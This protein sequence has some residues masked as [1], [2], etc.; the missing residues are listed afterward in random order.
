MYNTVGHNILF[1]IMFEQ[2][3]VTSVRK[4]EEIYNRFIIESEE[5]FQLIIEHNQDLYREYH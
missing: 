4:L 3:I 1:P 5:S 2:S